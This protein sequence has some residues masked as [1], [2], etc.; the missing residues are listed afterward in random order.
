[1]IRLPFLYCYIDAKEVEYIFL[2]RHPNE[3]FWKKIINILSNNGKFYQIS[4]KS[5]NQF[6]AWASNMIYDFDKMVVPKGFHQADK[7]TINTYVIN[8]LTH[9]IIDINYD[10]W[11]RNEENWER[12]IQIW[13]S[14][15]NKN[16]A[17]Q[18]QQ[19]LKLSHCSW[20]Y[21]SPKELPHRYYEFSMLLYF[22]GFLIIIFLWIIF[23]RK[24]YK[25]K[26]R[27]F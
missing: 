1:M 20:W 19:T 27:N 26:S 23:F 22:Y 21:K 5:S 7:N 10:I 16:E 2:Y 18:T 4:W 12:N 9:N 14:Y 8:K 17:F 6:I 15:P 25:N 11:E 3:V 13:Y 24:K